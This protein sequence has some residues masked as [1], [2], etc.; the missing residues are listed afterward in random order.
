MRIKSHFQ[1]LEKIGVRVH[2]LTKSAKTN[3]SQLKPTALLS[4]V[5]SEKQKTDSFSSDDASEMSSNAAA[6]VQCH[7]LL[8]LI[9]SKLISESKCR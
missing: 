8:V 5:G 3:R 1:T 4:S 7:Q 6:L 9:N 2:R